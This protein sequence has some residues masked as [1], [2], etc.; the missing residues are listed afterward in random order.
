MTTPSTGVYET[1][2]YTEE[3]KIRV[4]YWVNRGPFG[5]KTTEQILDPDEIIC[6]QFLMDE[7]FA[8]AKEGENLYMPAANLLSF[9]HEQFSREMS[10]VADIGLLAAGGAGLAAKGT[11]LARAIALLDTT[12]AVATITI[13]SFRSDIA[14][15]EGGKTFLRA[16]DTVNTLIA[17]YGLARVVVKLPETFK[18][19]RQAYASFRA[20]A[21]KIDPAH[22]KQIESE[23]E[24]LLGKADTAAFEN[25]AASLR[26]KYSDKELAGL[27]KQIEAAGGIKDPKQRGQ[28]LQDIDSQ[29]E[30]QKSNAELIE[31][32]K[33]ENPDKSSKEIAELAKGDLKVPN[34]P[35]GFNAEDFKRAQTTI[36]D[37]LAK[38]G[39]TNV[40]GFATG[41]RVTG[42]TMNPAK[43][44][45]FGKAIENF[46][47]RDLDITLITDKPLSNAQTKRIQ[48]AFKDAFG[49]D[50]GIRNIVD[51]RQLDYIPVY[52][53]IELEL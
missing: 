44:S 10:L 20:G 4:A 41:S 33:K 48:Q 23:T 9:K 43:A 21:D 8:N 37:A 2:E 39:F 36:K 28:A 49:Q 35:F 32:L 47:G 34:V 22:L 17:I 42:A 5:L 26:K 15:T 13:N 6:V 50:L 19:L 29:A 1:V 25:E 18:N 24:A 40:K 38:E 14:A 52:G 45:K 31:R 7:D 16:W 12:L 53:K 30:A 11:R 46:D 27:E 51:Q 3:G